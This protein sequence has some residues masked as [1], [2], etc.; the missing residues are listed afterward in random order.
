MDIL[1]KGKTLKN[2][3]FVGQFSDLDAKIRYENLNKNIKQDVPYTI[4]NTSDKPIVLDINKILDNSFV[5][6]IEIPANSYKIHKYTQETYSFICSG[7]KSSG[8][9]TNNKE[10]LKKACIILEG[11]YEYVSLNHFEG[12]KSS[13]EEEVA[14]KEFINY[15]CSTTKGT[16]NAETAI[17]PYIPETN[18]VKIV[19]VNS[20]GKEVLSVNI[21]YMLLSAEGENLGGAT[22]RSEEHTSELQS[23]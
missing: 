17:F 8:W 19:P 16:A 23:Q 9:S 18:L 15:P 4:I 1:I 22:P 13:G 20:E 21:G 10:Q 7:V 2:E 6:Q 12:I 11:I 3:F 14:F 5:T